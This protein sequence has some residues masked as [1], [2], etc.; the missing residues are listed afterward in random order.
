[1]IEKVILGLT[2]R[3][4][5]IGNNNQLVEVVARIDTGATSSSI[6]SKLAEEL[7]LGPVIS[8]KTVK[9]A[10]GIK[11]RPIVKAKIIM[12]GIDVEEGF[13]LADRSHMTYRILIGQNILK[14]GNFL[15]DP[16]KVG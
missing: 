15:I 3:I 13:T 4:K 14:K 7:S 10:S 2:E 1:M 16:L 11:K 9:S 12:K 6:D 8:L 5:I